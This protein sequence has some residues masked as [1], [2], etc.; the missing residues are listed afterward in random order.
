LSLLSLSGSYSERVVDICKDS[1]INI[2]T[3]RG[4]YVQ[5]PDSGVFKRRGTG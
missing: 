1:V 4:V 2:I 3:S 5:L